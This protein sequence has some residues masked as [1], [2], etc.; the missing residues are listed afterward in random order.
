MD[1]LARYG[2]TNEVIF[3]SDMARAEGCLGGLSYS[4]AGLIVLANECGTIRWATQLSQ[5]HAQAD[6]FCCS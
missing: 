2:I 1:L 3:N 6:R 4:H 5:Q